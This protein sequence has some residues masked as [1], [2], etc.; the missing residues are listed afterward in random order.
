MHVSLDEIERLDKRG[1][2]VA[3]VKAD[4]NLPVL[5]LKMEFMSERRSPS[6]PLENP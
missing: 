6:Q 5:L 3:A 4:A 1:F 2:A